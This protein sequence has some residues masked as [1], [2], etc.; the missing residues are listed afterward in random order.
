MCESQPL[1]RLQDFS[2]GHE[3]VLLTP[4]CLMDFFL[5]WCIIHGTPRVNPVCLLSM[6]TSHLTVTI[7]KHHLVYPML[8]LFP[9]SFVWVYRLAWCNIPFLPQL[10]KGLIPTPFA[11]WLQLHIPSSYSNCKRNLD[12][13]VTFATHHYEL[14]LLLFFE[15]HHFE[16]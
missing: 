1:Y 9:G 5:H 4:P 13:L 6:V 2:I 7:V 8:G 16:L 3:Q 15:N 10:R 11:K 14:L 12:N